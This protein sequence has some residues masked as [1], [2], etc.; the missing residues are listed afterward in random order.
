MLGSGD[1][2]RT[3]AAG[4]VGRGWDVVVGTRD[5]DALSEWVATVDDVDGDGTL[6]VGS[7]ADA[8][9]H[10][11]V[12]VL[13]VRGS[14]VEEVLELAGVERFAGSLVLDATNPLDLSEEGA[15]GLFLGTSDSLGE[16]V[17]TRLRDAA[18]VKCFNTVSHTQMVDPSFEGET[19][20]LFVCGDDDAAK[21]RADGLVRAFGWPGTFDVGD[22][23]AARWLEAMVPLWVRV[24]TVL[25]T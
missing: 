10:G 5:P 25:E 19:P 24:G 22:V 14:A 6:A 8:A 3:L 20:R 17:Q 11:D 13:A 12:A 23:R 2:G 21:Q 7:F 15:P 4:F 16:R 9:G 1:V 18:V